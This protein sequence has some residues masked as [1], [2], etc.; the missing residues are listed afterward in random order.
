MFDNDERENSFDAADAVSCP[1]KFQARTNAATPIATADDARPTNFV[2]RRTAIVA[3]RITRSR[4]F[5]PPGVSAR[6]VLFSHWSKAKPG[7][8]EYRRNC[9]SYGVVRTR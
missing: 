3:A 5:A 2:P 8:S 7:A 6:A 1:A 4:S 9:I